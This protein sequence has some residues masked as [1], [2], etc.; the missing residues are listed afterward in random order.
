MTGAAELAPPRA[1]VDEWVREAWSH[2][3]AVGSVEVEGAT[4]SYR[5]WSLDR[6]DLPGVLLAHGFQAHA[7]WW[8]HI[9]PWLATRHRVVAVDFSG[10]GD[11]GHRRA[12]SRA[13]HGRELLAVADAVGFERPAIVAHSYGSLPALDACLVAPERVAR[14]ILIEMWLGVL[15]GD[16]V[17]MP[18]S[19]NRV[20]PDLDTALGRYRLAPPGGWPEP[21]ILDH[22]A[23][24]SFREVKEVDDAGGGWALKFDGDAATSLNAC[25]SSAMYR[26]VT[27]PLSYV[28]GD[29]SDVVDAADIARCQ[30][31]LATCGP[32]IA[33]PLAHHHVMLEQPVALVVAL[34]ALL[35]SPV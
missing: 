29:R 5:G 10:F 26:A 20:Q 15:D 14:A 33:I 7:R 1:P 30:E 27:V 23:R 35:A 32:P 16:P 34:T 6:D 3:P 28:H 13:Q 24:H 2:A 8:D 12:Y 9:A 22:V 11:S 21:A 17:E 18:A 19:R 4:I 31:L 25:P